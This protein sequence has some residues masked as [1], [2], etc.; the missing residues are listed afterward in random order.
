MIDYVAA[1]Q[2][3][4]QQHTAIAQAIAETLHAYHQTPISRLQAACAVFDAGGDPNAIELAVAL[5][6]ACE[7]LETE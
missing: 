7:G 5:A 4:Y 1:L 6:A 2:D 3:A